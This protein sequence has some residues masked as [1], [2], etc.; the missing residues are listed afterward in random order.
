MSE[1]LEGKELRRQDELCVIADSCCFLLLP[2]GDREYFF[3]Q[4]KHKDLIKYSQCKSSALV[5]DSFKATS[6]I[7][8]TYSIYLLI[9]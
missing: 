6:V 1:F 9:D 8:V 4:D 7:T 3:S 2:I 5:L